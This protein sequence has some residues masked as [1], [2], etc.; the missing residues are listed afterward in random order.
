[1]VVD[2]EQCKGKRRKSPGMRDEGAIAAKCS[3][4]CGMSRNSAPSIFILQMKIYL[5]YLLE[6]V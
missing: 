4:A 2:T 1:V 3:N 6:I 5:Q